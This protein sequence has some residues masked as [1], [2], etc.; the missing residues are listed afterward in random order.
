MGYSTD[1]RGR[2][3]CDNCGT[4]GGVRKRTC[5]HKVTSDSLRGARSALPYCYPPAVCAPCFTKLGGNRQLH[6]RCKEGAAESQRQYDEIEAQLEAGE[7][8]S[9]TAWGDWHEKVPEGMVG[10]VF[11]GRAGKEYRVI[12]KADYPGRSV[13]LSTSPTRPWVDHP[14]SVTKR[15]G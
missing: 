7:S 12:A 10:L 4:S 8:L 11:H 13:A 14:G 1:M 3:C 15:V 6:A 2:L 9:T 5:P